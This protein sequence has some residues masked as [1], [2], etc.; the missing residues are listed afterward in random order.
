MHSPGQVLPSRSHN[1]SK[2]KRPHPLHRHQRSHPHLTEVRWGWLSFHDPQ[3]E[4]SRKREGQDTQTSVT[5]APLR[6]PLFPSLYLGSF[7][8]LNRPERLYQTQQP[9][10]ERSPPLGQGTD[11][12]HIG[13]ASSTQILTELERSCRSEVGVRR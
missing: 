7:D 1:D 6:P 13:L 5:L 4:S 2:K 11:T 9:L 8:L 10:E 3:S 12:K